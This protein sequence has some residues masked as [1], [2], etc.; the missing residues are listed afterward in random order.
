[1]FTL[2]RM[3]ASLASVA[4]MMNVL[5]N[6]ALSPFHVP[7]PTVTLGMASIACAILA[8]AFRDTPKPCKCD[9]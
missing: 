9:Q 8:V 1:M 7:N 2:L 4:L 5:F 3:I 6:G